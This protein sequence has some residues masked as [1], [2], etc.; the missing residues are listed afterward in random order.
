MSIWLVFEAGL[1]SAG[2]VIGSGYLILQTGEKI[3]FTSLEIGDS[4]V[5]FLSPTQGDTR[6][7]ALSEIR[8]IPTPDANDGTG[9]AIGA[10]VG[11][12]AVFV[13]R[14]GTL[15]PKAKNPESGP[16]QGGAIVLGGLIGFLTEDQ[17]G[18]DITV[19][20]RQPKKR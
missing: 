13:H 3:T 4:A 7:L 5:K 10:G 11:V 19:Y 12:A 1:T 16:I 6:V 15:G 18:R 20:P 14:C 8:S 2:E 17:P 9:I